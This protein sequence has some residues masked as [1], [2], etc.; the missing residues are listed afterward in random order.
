MFDIIYAKEQRANP[1]KWIRPFEK[2]YHN[3]FKTS[4]INHL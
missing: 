4:K 2:R 1:V 3:N